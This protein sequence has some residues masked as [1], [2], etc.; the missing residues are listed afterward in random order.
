LGGPTVINAKVIPAGQKKL[1][2]TMS[3]VEGEEGE[4]TEDYL[5]TKW[6]READELIT[7]RVEG[8]YGNDVK[9][10][11]VFTVKETMLK[12]EKISEKEQS[13]SY[14]LSQFNVFCFA[15]LMGLFCN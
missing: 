6:S 10:Q 8:I 2:F 12:R 3:A 11:F 7:Q 14:A 13:L 15:A 4:F 9:Y 5:A 1:V